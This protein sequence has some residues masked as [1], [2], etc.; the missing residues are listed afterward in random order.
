MKKTISIGDTK[1]GGK[2]PILIQSMCNTDTRDVKSTVQQ[3]LQLEK[4]GCEIIRVAVPDMKAALALSEIKKQIHIPLVADIHFDYKLAIEAIKQGVDKIRLNPGNIGNKEHIK[5]VVEA[6]KKKNIPIRIGVNGGSLEKDILHKYNDKATPDA[7]V[8]SAL[9]HVKILENLDFYNIIISVKASDVLTSIQAYKLLNQK[10]DYP[11]HLGI[12]E[13]GTLKGGTIKSAMGLG[14][15]L[16]EGIGSTIRISLTADPLEE[17]RAAWAILK[18]LELRT[19]GIA[20]TSCPGCGRT[21]IQLQKIANELEDYC[22]DLEK[23]IHIAVMGCVVNGPGEATSAD[24]GI[25]GGKGQTAIYQ[26]GKLIHTCPEE[27]VISFT[28]KLIDKFVK[29]L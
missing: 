21:E 7:L 22:Q 2:H 15:L 19:R 18:N 28:K 25:I 11:L 14:V 24:I 10:T 9:R 16:Y 6:C 27:E 20:F 26:E 29:K 1:I 13:A 4:A 12:T 3:I 8:E 23:I 5:A 17:V